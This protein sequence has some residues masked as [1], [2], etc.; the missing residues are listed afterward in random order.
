MM[1]GVDAAAGRAWVVGAAGS[2]C[3]SL[4]GG[5]TWARVGRGLTASLRAVAAAGTELWV[6]GEH[7]LVARRQG[8]SWRWQSL[9]VAGAVEGLAFRGADAWAAGERGLLA[10]SADGGA[11]WALLDTQTTADLRDVQIAEDGSVWVVGDRGTLLTTAGGGEWRRVA[12]AEEDLHAAALLGSDRVW[13]GGGQPWGER[14]PV[15]LRSA[16]GGATWERF[17][18]P[19]RGRVLD[20]AFATSNDGWAVVEDWGDDGDAASGSVYTTSD[21]GRTWSRRQTAPTVLTAIAGS[22]SGRGLVCG[23]SGAAYETVDGWLTWR[24]VASGTDGLLHDC[25]LPFPVPP[26]TGGLA[27]W[28]AGDDGAVLALMSSP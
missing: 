12:A 28:V 18:I 20:L 24:G 2:V 4:D 14:R 21:G 6:G 19:A 16:D 8:D 5:A 1:G 17:E 11:T 9:G 26:V 22:G 7:G 23:A 27:G 15:V 10:R 13:V 3:R 25:V